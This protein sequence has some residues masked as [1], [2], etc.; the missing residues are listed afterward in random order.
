[1]EKMKTVNGEE[2]A[3]MNL[4]PARFCVDTLLPQG[5]CILGGAPKVGKSWLV[6]DLCVRIAQGQPVW[7]Q[8][9]TQGTALYLCL[10]DTLRRVQ[11]RLNSITDDP[12]ADLYFAVSACSIEDGLCEQIEVF[13]KEHPDARLVVIDTFQLVRKSDTDISYSKQ[14][15]SAMRAVMNYC[16]REDKTWDEQS[17][18]R[19]VSGI[20]CNGMNSILEFETTKAAHGKT[21]GINFYQYVQS[22]SPAENITP[23]QAHEVAKDFAARAWPG[24]EI[25]VTTHCDAD[26]VHSHFIINS[27]NFET[28]LKLR[29]D[30]NTLRFLRLVSDDICM[31]HG[32]S[33]LPKYEGG[34]QKM[35]AREYRA[36]QKGQSWKFRLMYDIGNAMKKSQ[37]KE[38]FIILMKRKG[39]EVKW[40]DERKDITFTCPNGMKCRGSRLHHERYQ[41]ENFENEFR[42]RK[43]QYGRYLSG[44][45]DPSQRTGYGS[46][47]ADAVPAGS[48]RHPGGLA[49]GRERAAGASSQIPAGAV[50][51]HSSASNPTG[52]PADAGAAAPHDP[53]G[54]AGTDELHP[55]YPATGWEREREVFF[56]TLQNALRQSQSHGNGS[57]QSAK[58]DYENPHRCGGQLRSPVGVGLHGLAALGELIQDDN[59]DPE[60]KRQRILAEQNGS[61]IGAVL[62]LA[63]GAA[64]VLTE[65]KEERVIQDEQDFNEFLAQ[66]EAE[67]EQIWQ[68]MM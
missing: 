35:T 62:G 21:D 53:N 19:L 26:H 31:A 45:P 46:P 16:M 1:M 47:G 14:H 33:V 48:L 7:N 20:N 34:G 8:K 50:P 6:L 44:S 59:E 36:A 24:A 5:I 63:I 40:T 67:E 64:M 30:P 28:G 13:C 9:T 37:S 23:Q 27:V 43:Q 12:P 3:D 57:I 25:L 18:S 56:R 41:K 22:F 51:T 39:Y 4:P 66:T 42:L 38:D 54:T 32:F 10:E 58:E 17:Q 60:Q 11:D 2:L 61:D 55:Q 68:Q 52:V 49:F 29:Q 15:L 65:T